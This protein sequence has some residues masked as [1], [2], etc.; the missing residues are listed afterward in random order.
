MRSDH[1]SSAGVATVSSV[2]HSE[3]SSGLPEL[4]ACVS[5]DQKATALLSYIALQLAVRW[6]QLPLTL[7]GQVFVQLVDGF[8]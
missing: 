8:G 4:Q 7:V 1:E 3:N 2:T 5:A 6:M